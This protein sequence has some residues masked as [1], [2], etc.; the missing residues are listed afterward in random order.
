MN[1]SQGNEPSPSFTQTHVPGKNDGGE[2]MTFEPNSICAANP[3]NRG[4]AHVPEM[5]FNQN[6]QLQCSNNTNHNSIYSIKEKQGY[7]STSFSHG[8]RNSFQMEP[9]EASKQSMLADSKFHEDLNSGATD[10]AEVPAH[11]ESE[12][13]INGGDEE[14]R[15]I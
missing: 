9:N 7:S 4:G 14:S 2:P 13:T 5:S 12:I 3:L 10:V 6:T 8:D 11:L 1:S 15:Q